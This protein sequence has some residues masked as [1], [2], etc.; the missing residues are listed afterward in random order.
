MDGFQN[1]IPP[2][3]G[4][5]K[6]TAFPTLFLALEGRKNAPLVFSGAR[7]EADAV[8][9]WVRKETAKAK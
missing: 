6:V 3:Y 9:E 7:Q 2:E 5:Y 4:G 8:V 1:H